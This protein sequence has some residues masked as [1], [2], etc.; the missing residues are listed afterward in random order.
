MLT[1]HILTHIFQHN[2]LLIKITWDPPTLY[3]NHMI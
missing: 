3:G 1:T 2:F